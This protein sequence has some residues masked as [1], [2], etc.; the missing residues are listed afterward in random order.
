MAPSQGDILYTREG[1]RFGIAALVPAEVKLC[2]SQRMMAFRIHPDHN[3]AYAMWQIN[4][5]HAYAQAAAD[6][7][8]AA[9]PHVNVMRIRN[10]RLALP[11]RREQDE[12]V[13]TIAEELAVPD[14]AIAKAQEEIA[15]L[16]EYRTRLIADVVTGKLDVR[17]A[18]ARLPEE[19]EEPEAREEAEPLE[20]EADRES[21]YA[22]AEID[23]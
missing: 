1:E 8:G 2:I 21:E 20:E 5:R 18:A 11:P 19:V 4:C 22:E 12:I 3:S 15:L 6:L 13:N 9:A 10:F 14:A 23:A 17:E 7:I 16:R